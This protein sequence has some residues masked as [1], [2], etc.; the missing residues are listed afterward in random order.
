MIAIPKPGILVI[1]TN[2]RDCQCDGGYLPMTAK[3]ATVHGPIW[4]RADEAGPVR[5]A[6]GAGAAEA[7]PPREG[8]IP[9][10]GPAPKPGVGSENFDGGSLPPPFV[11]ARE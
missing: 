10:P 3:L 4:A 1:Q 8:G 7:G 6:F 5:D 9:N 11:T 2:S